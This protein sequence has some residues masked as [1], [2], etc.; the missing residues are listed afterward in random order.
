MGRP[1][2][3]R[4]RHRLARSNLKPFSDLLGV[5]VATVKV[6]NSWA[7]A[8][9][10]PARQGRQGLPA[11]REAGGHPHSPAFGLAGVNLHTWTGFGGRL[12]AYVARPRCTARDV[13]RRPIQRQGAARRGAEAV[14]ARGQ[15]GP[16]DLKLAALHFYQ[17]AIPRRPPAGSFNRDA[18]ARGKEIF[19]VK[20]KCAAATCPALHRAGTTCTRRPRSAWTPSG[21][22]VADAHGRTAPLPGS[23]A[24]RRGVTSTEYISRACA[25]SWTTTICWD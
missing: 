9:S 6:L 14:Q 2:P 22:P 5:D 12:D 24:T 3:E 13:L 16:R 21:R 7:P 18:A 19:N 11:R 17:L 23:G 1:G 25:R 4:P 8:A 20:G 10:T 15:S